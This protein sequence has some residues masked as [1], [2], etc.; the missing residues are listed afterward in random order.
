M[1]LSLVRPSVALAD[2]FSRLRDE[3]ADPSLEEPDFASIVAV[4]RQQFGA[5]I[6]RL[7][8]L[9]AGTIAS[10]SGVRI[11]TFWTLDERGEIVAV[12]GLRHALTPALLEYGGH[13]G[14][15]VRPSARRRGVARAT[16]SRLL[17]E[18]R[19]LGIARAR[20][21]CDATN[22]GSRRV[23]EGLDGALDDESPSPSAN[24]ALVRR[25]W[26]DCGV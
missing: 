19:A 7:R 11:S 25:Y 13:I 6:D 26:I 18:A 10:K 9:E 23:I 24:G 20:L 16:L 5:Y 15:A 3:V 12:S 4:D 1:E 22:V 17:E 14:F 21:T 2:A 8:G